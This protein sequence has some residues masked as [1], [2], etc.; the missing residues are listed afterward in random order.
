VS[1]PYALYRSARRDPLVPYNASRIG[2][3]LGLGQQLKLRSTLSVKP[4]LREIVQQRHGTARQIPIP[5]AKSA[6][7]NHVAS[8][9]TPS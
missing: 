3:R 4:Y 7:I 5:K 1:E 8:L 2:E 9:G 6:G